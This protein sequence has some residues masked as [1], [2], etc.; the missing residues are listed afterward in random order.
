MLILLCTHLPSVRYPMIFFDFII[1]LSTKICRREDDKIIQPTLY[2]ILDW[3][4][5]L[6]NL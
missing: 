3:P 4:T 2:I 1:Q 6:N 5:D